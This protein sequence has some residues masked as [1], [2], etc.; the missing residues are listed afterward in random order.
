M[1]TNKIINDLIELEIYQ[2]KSLSKEEYEKLSNNKNDNKI[3]L[4]GSYNNDIDNEFTKYYK[5]INTNGLTIEE[6]E[7]QLSIERTK[8]IKAIKNMIIFFVIITVISL[9]CLFF[10]GSSISNTLNDL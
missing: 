5:E 1:L 2:S 10:F 4:S 9:I 7:L 6:I 8:N 3:Y